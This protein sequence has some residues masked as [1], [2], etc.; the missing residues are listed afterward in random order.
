MQC[1]QAEALGGLGWLMAHHGHWEV[2]QQRLHTGHLEVSVGV[3]QEVV[4]E[5]VAD[6]PLPMPNKRQVKIKPS[7]L[8][9]LVSEMEPIVTA[10]VGHSKKQTLNRLY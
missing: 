6:P 2:L 10:V 1:H 7:P 9:L 4:G 8:C 5:G 3:G